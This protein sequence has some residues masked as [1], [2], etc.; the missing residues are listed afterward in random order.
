M[1]SSDNLFQDMM[2]SFIVK[3]NDACKQVLFEY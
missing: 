2:K 3:V 1:S